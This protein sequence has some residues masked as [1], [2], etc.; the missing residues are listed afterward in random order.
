MRESYI[1]GV[2]REFHYSF[3]SDL[4]VLCAIMRYPAHNLS[5]CYLVT[6]LELSGTEIIAFIEEHAQFARD[7]IPQITPEGR[8]LLIGVDD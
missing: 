5:K 7:I 2:D 3:G 6:E 1:K 4:D 8:Y